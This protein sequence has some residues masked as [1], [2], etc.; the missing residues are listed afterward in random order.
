MKP[1]SI[2]ISSLPPNASSEP[3]RNLAEPKDTPFTSAELAKFDGTDPKGPIY[4]AIKGTIFDVTE[5]RD[6]YGLG[7]S[8]HAFAGKDAS[9][10]LATS[11]LE[12]VSGD[13]S[14]LN[15]S[16][17]KTLDNWYS[18]FEQR[19]NIVGKVIS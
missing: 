6:F 7:G 9:K 12:D 18:Y 14:S 2:I 10:G 3:A 11:T 8:Y 19:Y 17:L 15:E 4:V 1:I 16:Q 5:K 13:Y